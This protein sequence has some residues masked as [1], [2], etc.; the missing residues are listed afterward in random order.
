[1]DR[2]IADAL[3]NGGAE[4]VVGYINNVYSVY[5]RSMLWAMVN[6]MLGG[7]TVQQAMEFAL[8]RYGENDIVWYTGQ[9]G[10]RPHAA[11]SYPVLSG[12]ENARLR[13]VSAAQSVETLQQAA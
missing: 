4:A 1:M 5:S 7:D 10:R 9:G 12:D 6:R 8:D 11:A 13:A 2:S 3:L